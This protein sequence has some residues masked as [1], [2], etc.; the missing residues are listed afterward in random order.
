MSPEC[1]SG[2][3]WR[4]KVFF[5]WEKLNPSN[6]NYGSTTTVIANLIFLA[7]TQTPEL[8][9]IHQLTAGSFCYWS[10][11]LIERELP[12]QCTV[13]AEVYADEAQ[14]TMTAYY[15]T[16]RRITGIHTSVITQVV[17]L[18]SCDLF[19]VILVAHKKYLDYWKII[20]DFV[21]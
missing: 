21:S 19:I 10:A 13:R 17:S 12:I 9:L 8:Q 11:C 18:N 7:D 15:W 3:A 14:K 20:Q 16:F 2:W 5:E 1:T 4:S 6:E